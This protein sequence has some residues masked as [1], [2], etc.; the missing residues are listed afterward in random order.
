MGP[1][2]PSAVGPLP[3]GEPALPI[4]P[5]VV[6]LRTDTEAPHGVSRLGGATSLRQAVG[7]GATWEDEP[8]RVA[9]EAVRVEPLDQRSGPARVAPGTRARTT[10]GGRHGDRRLI[11]AQRVRTE[12]PAR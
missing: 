8:A 7:P 9:A 12:A 1:P 10:E 4:E 11:A 5:G 6:S 3:F 2:S